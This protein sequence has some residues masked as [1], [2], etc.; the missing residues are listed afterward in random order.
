MKFKDWKKF[1]HLRGQGEIDEQDRVLQLRK[2]KRKIKF[3]IMYKNIWQIQC[4]DVHLM[5]ETKLGGNN[6]ARN[7]WD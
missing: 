3:G 7:T 1:K 4:K 2:Q 5:K 6:G